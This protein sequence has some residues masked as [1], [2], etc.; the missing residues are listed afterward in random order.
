VKCSWNFKRNVSCAGNGSLALE[1][2]FLLL[3]YPANSASAAAKSGIPSS[4]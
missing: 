2:V 4:P 3:V 1:C